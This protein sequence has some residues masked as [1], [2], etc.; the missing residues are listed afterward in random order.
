MSEE[1]NSSEDQTSEN[2]S[3]NQEEP[4]SKKVQSEN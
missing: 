1:Q 3:Q 4:K 2:T